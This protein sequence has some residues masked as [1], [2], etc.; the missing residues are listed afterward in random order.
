MKLKAGTNILLL[1]S[2]ESEIDVMN[3]KVK[4]V[5]HVR[6]PNENKSECCVPHQYFFKLFP[7]Q[8]M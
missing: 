2:A 5:V 1:L 4:L 6:G 3:R 7:G 8:L